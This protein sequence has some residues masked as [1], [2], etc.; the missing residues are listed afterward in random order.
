MMIS[1]GAR[2]T[3]EQY[4]IQAGGYSAVV[5]EVGAGLRALRLD[6]RPLVME[7][8]ESSGPVGAAGQLLIPWPNRIRDGRYTFDGR[9]E[10]L[11]ITEAA[12][13]NAIHGLTRGL[14]WTLD[15]KTDF[16]LR[17][18]LRLDPMPGYPH[19]LDLAAEYVL[20]AET[21]LSIVVT[22]TNAGD[23]AAPYGIGSH[24]YL[25]IDGGLDSEPA[26]LTV[27]AGLWLSVDERMIPLCDVP[28]AGTPYDFREARALRGAAL[29]TAYTDLVRDADGYARVTLGRG[30]EGVTLWFGAGLDWVQLFTGDPLVEP[31]RR[32]ALAV[33]P[34]S[35]PPNA[36][37]DGT[38]V[39]RLEPGASVLHTWGIVAGV[40][41]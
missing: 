11:V 13:A 15:A 20:S 31:Y 17:M 33:E 34:M 36:F 27:P 1:D 5:T 28:V 10:Q 32:S 3:G 40:E 25:Q 12:K 35:C 19:T 41:G 30:V 39:V 38:G 8:P 18:V 37:A 29:D 2:P 6:E 16:S 9:A 23:T 22:A 7:F 4:Q 26:E 24:A 21:G 14:P